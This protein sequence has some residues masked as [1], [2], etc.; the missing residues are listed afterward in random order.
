MKCIFVLMV[1][2]IGIVAADTT[3]ILDPGNPG[4]PQIVLADE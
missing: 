2:V 1:V 3:T 4:L